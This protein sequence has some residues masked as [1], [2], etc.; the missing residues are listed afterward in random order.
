MI[1]RVVIVICLYVIDRMFLFHT[2]QK[3]LEIFVKLLKI[4][5]LSSL[6]GLCEVL[7]I[8]LEFLTIDGRII[9]MYSM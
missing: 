1:L 8:F 3:Q 7:N 6:A 5:T 9:L 2:I 4:L